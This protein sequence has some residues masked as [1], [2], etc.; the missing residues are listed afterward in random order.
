MTRGSTAFVDACA[1]EGAVDCLALPVDEGPTGFW[2]TPNPVSLVWV[3]PCC[4]VLASLRQ[5][6]SFS[7]SEVGMPTIPAPVPSMPSSCTS[8]GFSPGW[9][10]SSV[11]LPCTPQRTMGMQCHTRLA[12]A[13]GSS[14][15]AWQR[16]PGWRRGR[17]APQLQPVSSRDKLPEAPGVRGSSSSSSHRPGK[18]CDTGEE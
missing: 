16:G 4:G 14:R 15:A 1:D 13:R 18:D 5:S 10:C 17:G 7:L 8:P 6:F 12:S 2:V 9:G 11:G 3:S